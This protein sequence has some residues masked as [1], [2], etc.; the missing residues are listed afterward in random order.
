MGASGGDLQKQ[1]VPLVGRPPDGSGK[2]TERLERI[3]ELI[4]T[5]FPLCETIGCFARITDVT[6]KT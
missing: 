4:R 6:G 5:Y 2:V 3:A 1:G